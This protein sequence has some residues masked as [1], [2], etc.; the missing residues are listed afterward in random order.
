MKMTKIIISLIAASVLFTACGGGGDSTEKEPEDTGSKIT[1]KPV[2]TLNKTTFDVISGQSKSIAI[3]LDQSIVNTD[4]GTSFYEFVASESSGGNVI[5]DRGNFGFLEYI[6]DGSSAVG[7]VKIVVKRDGFTSDS[8]TLT[9]NVVDRATATAVQVMKTGQTTGE[10]AGEE[11]VFTR[12]AGDNVVDALGLE[13]MDNRFATAE[14]ESYTAA[15]NICDNAD[16]RLPTEDE[17]YN[18]I[19]YGK[20]Y[21]SNMVSDGFNTELLS[22]WAAKIDDQK[23]LVSNTS[24]NRLGIVD[25]AQFR[26]VKGANQNVDHLMLTD[27]TYGDTYDLS[28]NLQWAQVE[29]GAA[30][31]KTLTE[32]IGYCTAKNGV[33]GQSGW[34]VPT[35]NELRSLVQNDTVAPIVHGGSYTLLSSTTAIDEAANYNYGLDLNWF[36]NEKPVITLFLQN[37]AVINGTSY[38]PQTVGISCVRPFVDGDVPQ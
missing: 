32:A 37:Q 4:D 15:E 7:S 12:S 30:G 11:R 6:N 18:I 16:F 13:W 28:T 23:I 35:I 27:A 20:A 2:V 17:L 26:C 19:D 22:S 21:K 14:L 5:L 3:P 1:S 8:V 25:N 31:Q 9:F 34:R 10:D 24:G 38:E 33:R 29:S 36:K